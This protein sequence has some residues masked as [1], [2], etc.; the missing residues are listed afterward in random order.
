MS[1]VNPTHS[2]TQLPNFANLPEI[3]LTDISI[4]AQITQ[5]WGALS[6][7][8]PVVPFEVPIFWPGRDPPFLWK[9]YCR[10]PSPSLMAKLRRST[11]WTQTKQSW[12]RNRLHYME[13]PFGTHLKRIL[14]CSKDEKKSIS[15]NR[16]LTVRDC[17]RISSPLVESTLNS[18]T[19]F[20]AMI[21]FHRGRQSFFK[22]TL[23][24][25][26][27][28]IV[29]D[30]KTFS[31]DKPDKMMTMQFQ[32]NSLPTSFLIFRQ[33]NTWTHSNVDG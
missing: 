18:E 28:L 29:S 9:K 10:A 7:N 22:L 11:Y 24:A 20:T 26:L 19:L 15:V 17:C 4:S 12:I 32:R 30:Q 5:K 3:L 23:F 1:R 8:R 2:P 25:F 21:R 33:Y 27:R 31:N 16:P 6:E 13:K 14:Y